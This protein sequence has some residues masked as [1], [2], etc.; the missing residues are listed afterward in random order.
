MNSKIFNFFALILL[1]WSV[2]ISGFSFADNDVA[3]G[4]LNVILAALWL[5]ILVAEWSFRG[6]QLKLHKKLTDKSDEIF[7]TMRNA[8]DS[9]ENK[10][11]DHAE[12]LANLLVDITDEVTGQTRGGRKKMP[13]PV[14][15]RKIE[16]IF[17][18]RTGHHAKMTIVGKKG[19]DVEIS[20][21]SFKK[22]TKK[23]PAKK[24]SKK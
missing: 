2:F 21:E 20:N 23:A 19:M 9:I 7:K 3:A 11:D 14:Q 4:I 8:L 1:I 15:M 12:K 24:A 13:T 17:N 10:E 5:S 6:Q 16:K 18:D 22:T